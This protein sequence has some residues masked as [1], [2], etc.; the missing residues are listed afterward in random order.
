[1]SLYT[2]Q[3]PRCGTEVDKI[4][5]SW[6]TSPVYCDCQEEGDTA[7]VQMERQLAAPAKFQWGCARNF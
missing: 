7:A 4:R 1:M 6:D 5:K 2:Y 3:C